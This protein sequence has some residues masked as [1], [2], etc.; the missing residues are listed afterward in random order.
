MA[1]THLTTQQGLRAAW[2][3]F[4]DHTRIIHGVLP[5]RL[6]VVPAAASQRRL[7]KPGLMR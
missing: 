3:A 1:S 5:A 7:P 6:N 4:G 2:Y